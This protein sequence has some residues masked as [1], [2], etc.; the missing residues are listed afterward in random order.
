MI[1]RGRSASSRTRRYRSY[2]P[3]SSIA[4]R[5]ARCMFSMMASSSASRSDASTID[6]RNIVQAGLL[7]GAP[8]PLAG[9]DLIG[10]DRHRRRPRT[11]IGW[12]MPFSR[13]EAA[14]SSRSSLGEARARIARIGAQEAFG[15][16]LL[17]A[18]ALDRGRRPPRH[19]RSAPRGRGRVVAVR[20]SAIIPCSCPVS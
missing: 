18:R 13:I 2:R 9:D 12:M 15:N 5:S 17:A 16:A 8:A 7:R 10:I 11:R 14:R 6:H 4:L 3:A 20:S 1:W 19:R